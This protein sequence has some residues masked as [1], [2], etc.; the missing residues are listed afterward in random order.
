MHFCIRC[1]SWE[2]WG[3]SENDPGDILLWWCHCPCK[4]SLPTGPLLYPSSVVSCLS[5]TNEVRINFEVFF[6]SIFLFLTRHLLTLSFIFHSLSAVC[7]IISQITLR[8]AEFFAVV[9]STISFLLG[10]RILMGNSVAL[11]RIA[12]LESLFCIWFSA[13]QPNGS[14]HWLAFDV[15]VFVC[16]WMKST[17]SGLARFFCLVFA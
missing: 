17:F 8:I 15:V 10:E 1:W 4:Q 3:W 2:A 6:K 7:D 9:M 14:N 11:R 5:H 13:L 12:I 16:W